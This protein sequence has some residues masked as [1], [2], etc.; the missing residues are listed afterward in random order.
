MDSGAA[1]LTPDDI[2]E[3]GLR[4]GLLGEPI[5]AA[6]ESMS[7]LLDTTDPLRELPTALP[8]GAQERVAALLVA[9]RLLAAG[10]ASHIEHFSLGPSHL[11]ARHLELVYVEPRRYTNV[12]PS[13]RHIVGVRRITGAG[14]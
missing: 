12:D 13:S 5:P 3:A 10:K 7:F 6:L 11:G 9:E 14:A 4:A 8:P 1:G 2:V